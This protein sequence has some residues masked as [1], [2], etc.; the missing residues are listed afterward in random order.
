MSRFLNKPVAPVQNPVQ[1]KG[2][3]GVILLLELS[4]LLLAIIQL[5][6]CPCLLAL[7]DKWAVLPPFIFFILLVEPETAVNSNTDS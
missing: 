3:T 6:G 4:L 2:L 1:F 5:A 7:L